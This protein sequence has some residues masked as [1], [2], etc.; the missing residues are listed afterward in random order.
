MDVKAVGSGVGSG[1]RA[2]RAATRRRTPAA[3]RG[4]V[5]CVPHRARS[6]NARHPLWAASAAARHN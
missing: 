2:A 5:E 4:A 6:A 1:A 3:G